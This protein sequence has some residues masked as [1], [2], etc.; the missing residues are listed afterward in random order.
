MPFKILTNSENE[1]WLFRVDGDTFYDASNDKN[2]ITKNWRQFDIEDWEHLDEA[3]LS[4]KL[5]SI[6]G[7][8]DDAVLIDPSKYGLV[9]PE[10]EPGIAT[11]N[12]FRPVWNHIRFDRKPVPPGI[13]PAN[14]SNHLT[15][16]IRRLERKL[17]QLLEYIEPDSANLN[18]YGSVTREFLNL[19]CNEIEGALKAVL[20]ANNYAG[21]PRNWKMNDYFKCSAP[22][23]LYDYEVTYGDRIS[24]LN[25]TK[26]FDRW[27]GTTFNNLVFYTSYNKVKHDPMANLN[28]ATLGAC[29][30]AFSALI[31]IGLAIFGFKHM[32]DNCPDAAVFFDSIDPPKYKLSQM[33]FVDAA[34]GNWSFRNAQ[35]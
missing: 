35:F 10:F 25:P 22:L 28:Q 27:A 15:N 9:D 33:Y 34:T 2:W 18:A 19:C 11:P 7:M 24:G 3:A 1:L 17:T 30:E 4:S 16:A 29:I 20:I 5:S 23:K 14:F 31:V 32:N 21:P 13:H 6:F 8:W 12:V 26:P